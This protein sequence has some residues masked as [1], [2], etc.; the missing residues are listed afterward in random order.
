MA[1]NWF[2]NFFLARNK[3]RQVV[4]PYR[5]SVGT[6]SDLPF[7]YCWAY[8]K[9]EPGQ[10]DLGLAR[11]SMAKAMVSYNNPENNDYSHAD[12]DITAFHKALGFKAI[13]SNK[14][15][16]EQPGEDTIGVQLAHRT[17]WFGLKRCILL[18]IAIRSGGYEKEWASNMRFGMEGHHDGFL[19]AARQVLDELNQYLKAN[20]LDKAK[21]LK[22]WISGYSRGG[23]VANLVAAKLL[24][25]TQGN[26]DGVFSGQASL[27]PKGKKEIY[28]YTFEAARPAIF[29]KKDPF[30]GSIFNLVSEEDLVPATPFPFMGFA[31][32]GKD[33][34]MHVDT[35]K[36]QEEVKKNIPE[37][38]VLPFEVRQRS[39]LKMVVSEKQ[40]NQSE[41]IQEL[42]AFMEKSVG[43]TRE[44]YNEKYQSGF[45]YAISYLKSHRG[46]LK[47]LKEGFDQKGGLLT[48]VGS[49][50]SK[51]ILHSFLKDIMDAKGLEYDEENLRVVS[52]SI[53][54]L[55]QVS[56][57]AD[58]KD[59]FRHVM[60]LL[61]NASVYSQAHYTEVIY[62][63]LNN[64]FKL[65]EEEK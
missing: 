32:Y 38:R 44:I 18:S 31:R 56:L 2:V 49:V 6:T 5:T 30:F 26:E 21:N 1:P 52:L 14:A 40:C 41:F 47:A 22:I 19:S 63:Y 64:E 13:Y 34:F 28:A 61:T 59:D 11:L 25:Q 51:N 3:P 54:A 43:L 62:S 9:H 16:L 24:S 57:K 65:E 8:F 42:L 12:R 60:S 46:S 7:S 10:F 4:T 27:N 37:F 29:K 58:M 33:I 55:V 39:K 35:A 36:Q 45:M 50:I 53:S 17:L 23:A 15:Y 48:I 20:K